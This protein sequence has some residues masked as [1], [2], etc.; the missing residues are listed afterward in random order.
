MGSFHLIGIGG[1]GMSV[2]A[3]LLLRAGEKVSGSDKNSSD[4]L[5]KL[6]SLGAEVWVGSAP[7]K[8][9]AEAIVLYSSAIRPEDPEFAWA[10]AH[11]HELWH[12]SQGLAYVARKQN[13]IA[14]AGAHGKTTTSGM[15]AVALEQA[16]RDPS[17]A[18]GSLVSGFG[19]G[20][21][22]GEGTDFVAEADESDGS[23]MNYRP[24]VSIITNIDPDHL[25]NYANLETYRAA[26]YRFVCGSTANATLILCLDDP[27][28]RDLL[29]DIN[30]AKLGK[31]VYNNLDFEIKLKVKGG[32]QSFV[33]HFLKDQPLADLP[34]GLKI[35]GYGLGE[36]PQLGTDAYY[37]VIP[38]DAYSAMITGAD[39]QE[40]LQL[41]I[42]GQHNLLNATAAFIAGKS[43][44]VENTTMLSGLEEF[45]GTARRFDLKG[46]VNQ[47][48][49]IDDYGHHPAEIKALLQQA[50]SVV[51][52]GKVRVLFQ[53][54]LISRTKAFAGWFAEVLDRADEAVVC[55]ILPAREDPDPSVTAEIITDKS[56]RVKY[57][58]CKETAANYLVDQAEPGDI[59]MT[60]GI[61]NVGELGPGMVERLRTRFAG[62]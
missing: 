53:P 26:F 1:S 11:G 28:C 50:K 36:D 43:L 15:L 12:R 23:F 14:V 45:G 47:I 19:T 31:L 8:I 33:Q 2:I 44:G 7:E 32:Q 30:A 35:Y 10:K 40:K 58:G 59:V 39:T 20:A 25:D 18:V 57:I 4:T 34:E 61:G 46:E 54:Y 41:K 48:R 37:Q 52:S 24:K 60:V 21:K 42:P 56:Q 5:N 49:V 17:F 6:A 16:K 38:Q 22:L 9:P 62:K 13:F 29:A 51:G 27:G 3:E 55:D